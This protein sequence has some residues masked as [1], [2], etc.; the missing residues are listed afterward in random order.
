MLSIQRLYIYSRVKSAY[1]THLNPQLAAKLQLQV[2]HAGRNLIPH[3]FLLPLLCRDLKRRRCMPHSVW[4][5][6]GAL[7]GAWLLA[8]IAAA[9]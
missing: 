8:T 5:T 7:Q 9:E 3:F 6:Q 4:G 2:V 1:D